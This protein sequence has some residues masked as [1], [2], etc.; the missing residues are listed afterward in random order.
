MK[1]PASQRAIWIPVGI[2][3]MIVAVFFFSLMSLM[4][5]LVAPTIP[6]GQI[7]LFRSA[8]GAILGY[9]WVRMVG[10]PLWGV[11]K[12]LLIF[13]VLLLDAH[14]APTGRSNGTL[15]HVPLHCG[16]NCSDPASGASVRTYNYRIT[17]LYNWRHMCGTARVYF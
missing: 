11:N 8:V 2:R 3:Y 9:W 16:C 4:A 6:T 7:V 12:K 13:R 5:K 15:L 14:Y 10:I 17:C 1:V